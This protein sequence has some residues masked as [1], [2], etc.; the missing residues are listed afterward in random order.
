MK[1]LDSIDQFQKSVFG[2]LDSHSILNIILIVFVIAITVF[3]GYMITQIFKKKSENEQKT[4][5]SARHQ[6]GLIGGRRR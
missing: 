5:R 1:L 2:W 6:S 3:A 4:V